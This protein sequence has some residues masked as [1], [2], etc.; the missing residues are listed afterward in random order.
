MAH[1]MVVVVTS[2]L[3]HLSVQICVNVFLSFYK[4]LHY[5]LHVVVHVHDVLG[6]PQSKTS[7]LPRFFFFQ[8]MFI[9]MHSLSFAGTYL[10]FHTFVLNIACLSMFFNKAPKVCVMRVYVYQCLFKMAN[11]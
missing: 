11:I 3:L 5:L 9:K 10:A 7:T 4:L 1:G 8:K 6:T 2:F